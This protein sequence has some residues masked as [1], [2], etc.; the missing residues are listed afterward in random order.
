[1]PRAW[2]AIAAIRSGGTGRTRS[3]CPFPWTVS[4]P[5]PSLVCCMSVTAMEAISALRSPSSAASRRINSRRWLGFVSAWR[6]T[7][8]GAGLGGGTGLR[9][10]LSTEEGSSAPRRWDRHW[11]KIRVDAWNE[12]LV[13]GAQSLDPLHRTRSSLVTLPGASTPHCLASERRCRILV[14]MVAGVR[15]WT[16]RKSS[17]SR[18]SGSQP[19]GM[20]LS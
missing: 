10:D 20:G 7:A 5:Q 6:I 4:V 19:W 3:F 12:F 17:N 8:S 1:M 15:P 9:M 13:S 16:L 2:C 14:S 11:K 18:S